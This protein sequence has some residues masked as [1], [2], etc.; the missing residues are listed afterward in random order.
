MSV[1]VLGLPD[2]IQRIGLNCRSIQF[3]LI[4]FNQVILDKVTSQRSCNLRNSHRY[5]SAI[6]ESSLNISDL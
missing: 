4:S 2:S 5:N 3:I 1:C 6:R